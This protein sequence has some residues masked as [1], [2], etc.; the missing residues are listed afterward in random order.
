MLASLV[1][2]VPSIIGVLSIGVFVVL[3]GRSRRNV[4]FAALN[5]LA[6]IW[7]IFLL[8]A[9][10]SSDPDT[11]LWSLRFALF[12]GQLMFVP[13]FYFTLFFPFESKKV[14]WQGILVFVAIPMVIL[15][16]LL[17]GPLGV[18]SV[19]VNDFGARPDNVGSLYVFSDIAG[20]VL[21]LF[22]LTN[23]LR[24]YFQSDTHQKS[25]IKFVGLGV[26]IALVIN[27]FTNS[28]LASAD[29]RLSFVDLGGLSLLILS[30]FVAFA[31]FK[32]GFLDIRLIVARAMGYI[33]AVGLLASILGFS[34]FGIASLVFNESFSTVFQVYASIATTVVVLTF[35]TIK[36]FFDRLTAR[37]FFRDS[38]DPQVFLSQLNKVIVS[39]IDI[40]TLIPKSVDVI[41]ANL[42]SEFT[43]FSLRETSY[44]PG[45]IIG[46][47]HPDFA[48]GDVDLMR[49]SAVHLHKAVIV[50]SEIAD[51]DPAL[52]KIMRKYGIAV[53]ARLVTTLKYDTEGIGF[54]A[55]GDKKSGNPY[56]KQDI[57]IIQIISGELVIAIE[58][59]LRFE[60]IE[61]FNAT[62]Q[63]KV[64]DATMKLK[65][66]NEKLKAMD[67]TK[68]EFISMASHQ[69]R[70][71]LT[72]VK[73]YVS[74]VLEGDAGEINDMQRKLLDQAFTSSQRMVFLIADLL[75]L[76]RLRTGK[77]I[78]EATP[79]NLAEVIQ[80]EV[81]QLKETAAGRSLSLNYE[82]PDDFPTLMLDETKIRQVIMNFVDNA[83]YYTPAGGK[84]EIKLKQTRDSIEFTVHDNGIGVPKSEQHHLFNKFYRA[85]NAQKARPDGTGLG[86]FM[87]K[88][89][90]V[91]Q[92][93]AIIFK[94]AENKGS[95][96]GFIFSKRKLHPPVVAAMPAP[97]SPK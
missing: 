57:D 24:K 46:D 28:F 7:L 69:L 85:R 27:V 58:N 54:L 73:G 95:T 15:A 87:A 68:D 48:S 96:F 11:A 82:K 49:A 16:A 90:V 47:A 9:D 29:T 80:G 93:G 59:A 97:I 44:T 5:F 26:I 67:E 2:Y 61:K 50:A 71:P 76:S 35:G 34:V 12:F 31:M 6:A 78:I 84:I 37:L 40:D 14:N 53:L 4:M 62:L 60:E 17:L 10:T 19:T 20:V 72:S 25:Q 8:L 51:E 39:N 42:K 36:R 81:E 23:L 94:S 18:Q 66:A 43:I 89:V 52:A 91:A 70:T 22:G 88:K 56:S 21:M 41:D 32:H 86:L 3:N 55:L 77:F 30:L 13:F 1:S 74:M 33:L 65:R 63:Q 79:T 83:I 75:N 38:Y 64:D 92:G 45:R